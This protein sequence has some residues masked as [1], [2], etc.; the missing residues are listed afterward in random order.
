MNE[1]SPQL[2]TAVPE[3]S[4][5]AF[6]QRSALGLGTMALA[7]LLSREGLLAA[8]ETD[9]DARHRRDVAARPGHFAG[10]AKSIILLF[11]NG[12]PSQM[13]LFDPKPELSSRDGQ[14]YAEKVEVLQPGNSDKLMASPFKFQKH[15][16]CGMELSEL[17]PHFGSVAD[18][19][20]LVRSMFT[21][22]NN[23][24]QASRLFLT[25]KIFPGRPTLGAWVSYGLGTENQSLPAFVALRDPKGYNTGGG[26][27]WDS[28]WLPAV[29][30]ATEFQSQ[31]APVLNL[32][33][34]VPL[35]GGAQRADLDLL[36][37]LNEEHRRRFPLESDLEARI[38]HYELAARMQLSAESVL[39]LS[40]ET[41]GT[42]KMYGM[43]RPATADY[44]KRCLMA[45]RLVESGVR[46]VHI[47]APMRNPWDSHSNLKQGVE[48]I[49]AKVDQPGAALIRDLKQRGLLDTTIVLWSGE[50]GRLPVSQNGNGR[51]HNRNAFGLFLA[52]G[53]F[54]SGHIH[55]AT[56]DFGYKAAQGRV[57]CP[58]LMATLLAQ[59]GL[60]HERLTYFH[61]GR[62]ETLTDPAVSRARVV[63]EILA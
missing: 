7:H 1:R 18:E 38:R 32:H 33:P 12:G 42:Q 15:G 45:R 5:R 52:G 16:E 34:A 14:V 62:Q 4:R 30:R 26:L 19:M 50:F 55:G 40:S 41:E 31:G 58:D 59:V 54:K 11:Q 46:F 13:D 21:E 24:P 9:A 43:D 35:P 25:G 37:Q 48:E 10:R 63:D 6:L 28:G 3:P 51:D 2:R 57:S 27:N 8:G 20:C 22:N 44:G 53:G 17:L 36:A 23:H 56:D 47:D 60:D 39:D 61:N 29:C 49:A